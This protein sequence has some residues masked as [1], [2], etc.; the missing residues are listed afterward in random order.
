M[1]FWWLVGAKIVRDLELVSTFTST[2][3]IIFL[4]AGG[5]G[6]VA[7]LGT[8]ATVLHWAH[9]FISDRFMHRINLVLSFVLV[10]LSIYF[11]VSSLR[12][13]M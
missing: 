6:L 9:K 3:S 13:L 11:I 4:I 12:V 1:I 10:A 5:L 7:Y 2:Y 8:L